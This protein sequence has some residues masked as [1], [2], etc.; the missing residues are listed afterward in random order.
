MNH[1]YKKIIVSALLGTLFL[2]AC[3]DDAPSEGEG[4]QQTYSLV[5]KGITTSGSDSSEELRDVSVFQF[6]DGNLYKTQ[7]LTPEANG[8]SSVSAL[9]GSRL[10]FLTG[11]TLPVQEGNI[12]EEEFRNMTIGEGLHDNSAPDFMAAVVELESS[13][14]TRS[15]QEINVGMKRG[16]ARID[17]NTTADSKTLIKEV[18]VEDAPAETY[19]F[20]ENTSASD[21]TVSYLKKFDPAFGGEQQGIFRIFESARPVNITLRGTYDKIPIRL[22]MQLPNIERNKVY[23]LSVLNVGATVEGIFEI[24]PWEEGETIIGKPDTEHRILLNASQSKIP[25]GVTVDYENNIVEVPATGVSDMKLAFVSDTRIDISATE[26]TGS[27]VNLSEMSV[28]EET[29]GIVSAFN[30]SVAAQG[31]GRL[32]YTIL[33]HLKNALLTGSYDYVEIRVAPSDKQIETVEMGGSTWMAFNAR[34]RDLEDQV[35]PLDGAT[36]EEMYHNGWIS[37]IGGLFQYGRK[38]MY[39]PW[40]G[41]SPSNNLG[42]QT[43]DAPWQNDTHMPCPEGYRVPTRSELNSLLPKG[44]EIP[45]TYTAG[46]GEKITATLHV[47]EGTLTTP[48]GVTGTQHYVK[49]TSE[50]TGRYLIIPLAGGKGDKSTTNN[51]A[52]GKRAVLWTSE[53]NGCPGGYAWAY[54]LPFEGKETTA[55][56]ERQLQMEAFA[57]LRCVKK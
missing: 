6:S 44:Q 56:T 36:V 20:I 9:N 45:S 27:G 15:S 49:F 25:E 2:G 16:V 14:Q 12:T 4:K 51:P 7:Q 22:K 48:T 37:S 21:K 31:N 55:I 5:V 10:Y 35:Y 46:N 41:Y 3:S 18:I 23:E 17:L 40:Q 43:A 30:V 8:Q 52:F 57:S 29:E 11:V 33:V 54:W 24:K 53:R 34:S 32:G 47:G 13:P 50:D 1:P 38:Y 39:I 19:P 28:S 26:G 42:N